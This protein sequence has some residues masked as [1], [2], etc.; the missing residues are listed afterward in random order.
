MRKLVWQAGATLA[1]AACL[2]APSRAA[3]PEKGS[4]VTTIPS[5]VSN[6]PP[7]SPAGETVVPNDPAFSRECLQMIPAL[8]KNI[9]VERALTTDT[10]QWGVVLRIDFT[11][12]AAQM[13]T[14]A[15][16][17]NRLV[18]WHGAGGALSVLIAVGQPMAPLP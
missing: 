7:L 8:R 17:V 13:Q 14:I 1:L 6:P 15:G 2:C 16:R 18:F 11:M 12:A 4:Y 5:Q 3:P 9:L 10:K